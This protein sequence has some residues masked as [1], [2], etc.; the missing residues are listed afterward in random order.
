MSDGRGAVHVVRA[1]HVESM[2]MK[3]GGF[4]AKGVLDVD[5]DLVAFGR[6]D[7]RDG[8]LSVDANHRTVV[9]AVGVGM[10][11]GYVKVVGDSSSMGC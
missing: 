10:C 8:P 3:T 7:G 5:D 9:L 2:E 4:I 1:V 6:Y 11:P